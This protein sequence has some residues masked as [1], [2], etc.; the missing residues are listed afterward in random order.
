[1]INIVLQDGK[2][3]EVVEDVK[4]EIKCPIIKEIIYM[5]YYNDYTKSANIETYKYDTTLKAIFWTSSEVDV[6]KLY[7][8]SETN[9]EPQLLAENTPEYFSRITQWKGLYEFTKSELNFACFT[10]DP[11]YRAYCGAY[12]NNLNYRKIVL[13]TNDENSKLNAVAVY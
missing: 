7:F 11:I 1:M 6:Y 3:Y 2:L 10:T 4:H 5:D 13:T 12:M 9:V 8:K